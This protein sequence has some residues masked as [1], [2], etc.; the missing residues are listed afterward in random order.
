MEPWKTLSRTEILRHS[1]WLT[2]ENH[3]ILLPDGT[4][5]EKWPWIITPDYVNIA[6][7]TKDKRFLCFRQTKYAV[8]G[9]SLAPIGGY[10]DEGEQPLIAARRELDE[11]TGYTA[12]EWIDLG[13]FA[14]DGNHGAGR[15]HLFLANNAEKQRDVVS[16]DLEEQEPVLL[17]A[18]ELRKAIREGQFKVLSWCAVMTLGLQYLGNAEIAMSKK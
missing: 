12:S 14:V 15:A 5:L 10:V 8:P 2:V 3:T 18:D 13:T 6:V 7:R 4:T 1:K 16:D 17:S 11:E 9:T